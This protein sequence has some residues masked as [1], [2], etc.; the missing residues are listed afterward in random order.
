[1]SITA[2][3]LI[4]CIVFFVISTAYIV[5]NKLPDDEPVEEEKPRDDKVTWWPDDK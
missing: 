1:M 4:L 3:I 2:V 5:Y